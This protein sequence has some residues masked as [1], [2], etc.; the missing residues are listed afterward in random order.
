M[1]HKS[2]DEKMGWVSFRK[3]IRKE[4]IAVTSHITP[5]IRIFQLHFVVDTMGLVSVSL[6]ELAPK[7]TALGEM[8]Q[9]N[10]HY[11]VRGHRRSPLSVSIE[12]PY[13]TSSQWTIPTYTSYLAP[14]PRYRAVSVK[15]LLS[16]GDW[17]L[18]ALVRG[19]L[20]IPE[21]RTAKFGLKKLGHS[22]MVCYK[23]YFD[24]RKCL[25]VTHECDRRT[26]RHFRSKCR[27]Y[28]RCAAN[29]ATC[30]QLSLHTRWIHERP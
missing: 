12:R 8:V 6:T 18:H 27:A 9:N 23:A 13:E 14:F 7:A 30:T 15:F 2:N 11:A 16:T 4:T 20:W 24:I 10:D 25:G 1:W 5:K 17:C 3:R 26:D 19:E 28:L 29:Y 22:S 21:F